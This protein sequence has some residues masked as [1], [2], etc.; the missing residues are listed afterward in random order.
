MRLSQLACLRRVKHC[1]LHRHRHLYWPWDCTIR[2]CSFTT[3]AFML[4]SLDRTKI[5]NHYTDKVS[6]MYSGIKTKD[7][8]HLPS[9][10]ST[11]TVGIE[12]AFRIHQLKQSVIKRPAICLLALSGKRGLR[13]YL[14]FVL[15]LSTSILLLSSASLFL[16]RFLLRFLLPLPP[17]LTT[18]PSPSSS[19]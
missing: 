15:E 12:F 13:I 7:E 9:R 18:S 6:Y 3:N 2:D 19:S 4:I 11:E 8:Y 17:L 10:E 5:G 14:E 1:R 16:L